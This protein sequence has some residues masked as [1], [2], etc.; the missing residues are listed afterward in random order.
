MELNNKYE[1]AASKM[2]E[3]RRSLNLIAIEEIKRKSIQT[4]PVKEIVEKTTGENR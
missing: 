1:K 3:L 4:Q 2:E